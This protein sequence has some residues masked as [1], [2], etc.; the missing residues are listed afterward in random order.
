MGKGERVSKIW[1]LNEKKKVQGERERNDVIAGVAGVGN[2]HLS[3]T[4]LL[5]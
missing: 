1:S 3:S 2:C 5:I 4:V